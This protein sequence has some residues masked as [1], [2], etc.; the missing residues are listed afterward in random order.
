M[1][2]CFP[3]EIIGGRVFEEKASVAEKSTA[4]NILT[5]PQEPYSQWAFIST[6]FLALGQCLFRIKIKENNT[7]WL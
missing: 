6:H 4:E 5:S 2:C 3:E 7:T 1:I